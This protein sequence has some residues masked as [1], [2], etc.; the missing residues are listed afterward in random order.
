MNGHDSCSPLITT[1]TTK[2]NQASLSKYKNKVESTKLPSPA[3]EGYY[4]NFGGQL[5]GDEPK[6][7]HAIVAES[8]VC[9]N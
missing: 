6:P 9:C 4:R 8:L 1:N 5:S 2:H 7:S 3:L